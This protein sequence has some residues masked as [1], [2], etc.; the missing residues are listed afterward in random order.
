MIFSTVYH[1][2]LSSDVF[3]TSQLYRMYIYYIYMYDF[4][5]VCFCVCMRWILCFCVPQPWTFDSSKLLP[6]KVQSLTSTKTSCVATLKQIA[7][8]GSIQ[9]LLAD[10]MDTNPREGMHRVV[11][12]FHGSNRLGEDTIVAMLPEEVVAPLSLRGETACSFIWP[13]SKTSQFS[14]KSGRVWGIDMDWC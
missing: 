13:C 2:R 11:K 7:R 9:Q 1:G 14:G 5:Q 12:C 10:Q 3:T 8:L 4:I 6:F